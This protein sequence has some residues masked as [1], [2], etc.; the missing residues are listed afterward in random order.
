[1]TLLAGFGAE[2]LLVRMLIS[3]KL[4]LMHKSANLELP[5]LYQDSLGPESTLIIL[6]GIGQEMYPEVT[7]QSQKLPH[8]ENLASLVAQ[9]RFLVKVSKRLLMFQAGTGTVM[10]QWTTCLLLGLFLSKNQLDQMGQIMSA[11]LLRTLIRLPGS[12][13]E[14][15][16]KLNLSSQDMTLTVPSQLAQSLFHNGQKIQRTQTGTGQGDLLRLDLDLTLIAVCPQ[17]QKETKLLPKA[18][19]ALTLAVIYP[20]NQ[21][22]ENVPLTIHGIGPNHLRSRRRQ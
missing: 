5:T 20:L 19:L 14:V 16:Q 4:L 18:D 12:G 15:H 10:H 9:A 13:A 21:R 22:E 8:L 7:S 3:Q 2:A 17:L 1:M 11:D 6:D